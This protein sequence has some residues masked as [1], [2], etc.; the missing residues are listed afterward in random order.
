MNFSLFANLSL[1]SYICH[2]NSKN[3]TNFL[4]IKKAAKQEALATVQ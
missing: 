3:I 2:K 4:K 1:L